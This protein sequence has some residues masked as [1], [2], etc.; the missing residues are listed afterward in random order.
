MVPRLAAFVVALTVMIA[1][2]QAGAQTLQARASQKRI[3][4]RFVLPRI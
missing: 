3:R 4:D 1:G 2:A